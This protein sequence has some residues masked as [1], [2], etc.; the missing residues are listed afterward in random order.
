MDP[1]NILINWLREIEEGKDVSIPYSLH[2]LVSMFY[3]HY[4]TSESIVLLEGLK[5]YAK[6][7]KKERDN[8]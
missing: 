3:N 7:L 4:G 5:R 2:G 1:I 6:E 8:E